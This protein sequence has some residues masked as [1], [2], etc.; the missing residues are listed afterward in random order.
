[1][2][3]WG[4]SHTGGAGLRWEAWEVGHTHVL[5]SIL[6]PLRIV[7]R[8]LRYNLEEVEGGLATVGVQGSISDPLGIVF[9]N[10]RYGTGSG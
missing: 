4:I 5:G 9:R 2:C 6:D 10:L 7:Y 8:N 1:M 3:G